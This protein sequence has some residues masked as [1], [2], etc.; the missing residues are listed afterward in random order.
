VRNT[1]VAENADRNAEQIEYPPGRLFRMSGLRVQGEIAQ[2]AKNVTY[3]LNI[4][5]ADPVGGSAEVP[6]RLIWSR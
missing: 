5:F 1:S 6:H 2:T 4:H 3:R